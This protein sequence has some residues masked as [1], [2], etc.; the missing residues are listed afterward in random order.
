MGSSATATSSDCPAKRNGVRVQMPL[1]VRFSVRI[2]VRFDENTQ[3]APF[4]CFQLRLLNAAIAQCSGGAQTDLKSNP[5]L[6]VKM[7]IGRPGLTVFFHFTN[8]EHCDDSKVICN[9][10]VDDVAKKLA[11]VLRMQRQA[12][13]Q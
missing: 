1:G 5:S 10:F 8:Q 7:S 11:R 3:L 6:G 9:G 2:G 12:S 13:N 4:D